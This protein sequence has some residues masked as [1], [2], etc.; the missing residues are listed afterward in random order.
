MITLS[1]LV[2][3]FGNANVIGDNTVVV[4]NTPEN[5]QIVHALAAPDQMAIT[6]FTDED[7]QKLYVMTGSAVP[8]LAGA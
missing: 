5:R 4:D 6:A 1:T 8:A 2:K 7:Q 3:S